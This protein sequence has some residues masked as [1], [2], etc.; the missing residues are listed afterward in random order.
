MTDPSQIQKARD[1]FFAHKGLPVDQIGH[2]ILRSWIRCADMGLDAQAVPPVSA[3]TA[4]EI[5][6]LHEKHEALRRISRPELDAL[7]TEAREISGIVILTN[8]KGEILDAVGDPTFA[9]K[10]AQVALRPG[11]LWSEDGTGTNAI[12]TALAERRA[13][14]V[15]GAEHYFQSHQVLTCAATPII[16]PRGAI[17]GVLD[18]SAPASR[19]NGHTIG[20]VRMAVEQIEHRLFRGGFDGCQTLRFQ[21]D[22]NLLGVAREGI[23]VVRNGIIVAANRRGLSLIGRTWDRLDELHVEE[24]F[25]VHAGHL[26]SGRLKALDGRDFFAQVDG[27]EAGQ[28]L[29]VGPQQSLEDIE[30]STIRQALAAHNG[31]V[32]AAARHLGIHR[33]T[34]YRRIPNA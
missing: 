12:G 3:P 26:A 9:D 18:I 24:V 5:R 2:S 6:L 32:S 1:V 4:S 14:V 17:I 13:V 27:E 34:I 8:A 23:L 33:S 11:A 29:P 25:D 22:P 28:A 20:L 16:D 7:Y 15:N 21:T 31:N 30:L 10:A 19:E